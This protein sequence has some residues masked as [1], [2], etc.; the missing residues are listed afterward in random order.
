MGL[1]KRL[2]SAGGAGEVSPLDYFEIFNYN[3]DQ[4]TRTF[5]TTNGFAPDFIIGK[6]IAFG[7]WEAYDTVRKSNDTG[8]GRGQLTPNQNYSENDTTTNGHINF[9]SNGFQTEEN[10]SSNAPPLNDSTGEFSTYVFKAGG[11]A[12]SNTDGT[13]TVQVSANPDA[14]FSI[15]SYDGLSTTTENFGHGLSAAPELIL[16]KCRNIANDWAVYSSAITANKYLQLNK[17]TKQ[18]DTTVMFND[19]EPTS[20]VFT[21]GSNS[22]VN[23]SGGNY[24]AYCF[25]S[26]DGIQ[27][28]GSYTGTGGAFS[29]TTGF[30]PRFLMIKRYDVNSEW[31]VFDKERPDN[32]YF[33]DWIAFDSINAEN[34]T[35]GFDISFDSDG[36][37]HNGLT[38]Y[39]ANTSGGSYLY[40][41]IA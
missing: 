13:R 36:W 3:G 40:W 38:T 23:Q 19:T 35:G 11:A 34:T 29:I 27:K 28:F 5:T 24:I 17:N 6:K 39:N 37:T 33:Q 22:R 18:A 2:I 41:A 26:V 7:N 16:I 32:A 1:N 30:Q 20:S 10:G 9:L 31:V 8:D 14:G 21:V 4:N 25:H 12:V 15:V